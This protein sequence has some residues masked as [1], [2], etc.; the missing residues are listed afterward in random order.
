MSVVTNVILAFGLSGDDE[1]AAV[2]ARANELIPHSHGEGLRHL[3]P[4]NHYGGTKV[5]EVN[6]AIGALNHL[7]LDA[8]VEALRAEDWAPY[9]CWFVQLMVQGQEN[10]GFGSIRIW[11]EEGVWEPGDSRCP[12]LFDHIEP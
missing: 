7:D 1:G 3:N 4:S 12:K 11:L 2:V 9:D 5:L 10:D 8:W 6:L